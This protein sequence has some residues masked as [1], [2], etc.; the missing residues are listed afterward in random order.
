MVAK[1]VKFIDMPGYIEYTD[2]PLPRTDNG[3]L[4]AA[5]LEEQDIQNK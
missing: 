5:L 2:K 1:T 3:K 4:N